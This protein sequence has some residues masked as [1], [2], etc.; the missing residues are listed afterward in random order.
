LLSTLTY[1][2]DAGGVLIN[3]GGAPELNIA[4]STVKPI[5]IYPFSVWYKEDPCYYYYIANVNADSLGE[6]TISFNT[7]AFNLHDQT[8]PSLTLTL[9]QQGNQPNDNFLS[10]K[11]VPEPSTYALFGLGAIGMLTVMRRKKTA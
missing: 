6:L 1:F 8:D 5:G 9:P 11:V 7:G 10:L 2:Q 4:N 3:L